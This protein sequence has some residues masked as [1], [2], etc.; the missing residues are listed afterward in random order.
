MDIKLYIQR[1]RAS[2][3]RGREFLRHD[4]WYIGKP[5]ETIPS[6]F[7]IQQLRV[8]ILLVRGL[9]EESLLL[10]ASALTFTTLL[11]MVPFLVFM[12][13][14]IQTF[15]L[16]DHVYGQI[17]VWLNSRIDQVVQVVKVTGDDKGAPD[18][19][20]GID[21]AGGRSAPGQKA[22][23]EAKNVGVPAPVVHAGDATIPGL[24]PPDEGGEPDGEIATGEAVSTE[25]DREL[26]DVILKT[27][28]PTFSHTA[29]DGTQVDPV[30]FLV[31][32]VE[33]KATD[34]KTLGLTGLMYVLITVL[35]LMRNVE[36]AFNQIWGVKE[37][38]KLLRTLSDYIMITLLLPVVA[39][40]M[41][42]IT[43]A[44]TTNESL[45]HLSIVLRGSQVLIISLT[46]SLLYYFVPNTTVH[47]RC[48]LMGGLV[49]GIAWT[50]TAWAYVTF[51]VGM[52]KYTFFFSAFALFPMLLAW[53]YTSWV[54]LLFGSLVTFA[55][56]NEKTFAL[57]RLA[58]RASFAYREAVAVR[59]MIDMARRFGAG[60]PALSVGEM[61]EAWNVPSRLLNEALEILVTAKF[62]TV[63]ATVP[64]T[65][66][67][68]RAADKIRVLDVINALRE[69]GEDPS[70]LRKEEAYKSLY[71][72]LANAKVKAAKATLADLLAQEA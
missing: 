64:A 59:I 22:T 48:A 1:A 28:F 38:R 6:G 8:G 62:V 60:E 50:L 34:I 46:F 65:Y 52:A 14:F 51:N 25:S 47:K 69:D 49:A 27:M 20:G 11:F 53:I 42:G 43:A 23:P 63:C 17:S 29:G 16:G 68:S 37:T 36:W 41:L 30:E 57:E 3:A 40:V 58:S 4:I 12:F 31:G 39:A 72:G 13:S 7:V 24:S 33:D 10:R 19:D 18:T 71:D 44:L 45:G 56:Q 26:A 5:G 67:P 61:A 21:P 2:Y 55:Y 35:G 54:I 9:M 66:L 32:M 15:H 70:M